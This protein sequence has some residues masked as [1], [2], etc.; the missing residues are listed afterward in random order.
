V[1]IANYAYDWMQGREWAEPMTYQGA[2]ITARDFRQQEKPEDVVDFDDDSLNPTFWY[3]DDDG[4]DHEVWMLDAVTAA[5]QWLVASNY[6]IRGAAVWALGMTDPSIWTFIHRDRLNQPPNMGVLNKISFPYFLEFV[7]EGEIAHVSSNPT[8]GSRSLEVDP[9]TGLALDESYH[10]FPTSYV[11][12]RTGY[13]PK[14]LS[15]T[16]DD[17]P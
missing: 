1:G 7:G 2:L 15:I 10:K 11:I 5:N 13:H 4:K 6:G 14:L 9:I 16:I 8:D 17:G 12:S 3:V